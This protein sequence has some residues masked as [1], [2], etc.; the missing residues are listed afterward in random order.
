MRP[1]LDIE[2]MYGQRKLIGKRTPIA[3][4]AHPSDFA[5]HDVSSETIVPAKRADAQSLDSVD[6]PPTPAATE[7]ETA[8]ETDLETEMEEFDDLT[9]F[10]QVRAKRAQHKQQLSTASSTSMNGPLPPRKKALS[11]HDLLNKYFRRDTVIMKN[12]DFLRYAILPS[13]SFLNSPR[14][15]RAND[16]MLLLIVTYSLGFSFLPTLTPKATLVL[17]FGHALT[18]CLFHTFGLGLLLRA[19]SKSKFLVRHFVKNYHYANDAGKGAIT[20]AFA[21]WKALY[22]MSLCMT[23]GK[24]FYRVQLQRPLN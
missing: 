16:A 13:S 23:Y 12:F 18:W 5:E 14:T 17:H 20:E 7:G 15:S 19:Q 10:D 2:R 1:L 4:P 24:S 22:N 9:N 8:T 3:P 6:F 11:H 21:N